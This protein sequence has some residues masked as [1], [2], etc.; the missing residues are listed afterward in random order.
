M[1]AR[2]KMVAYVGFALLFISTI[3]ILGFTLS[4]DGLRL[5]AGS[6]NLTPSLTHLFGTDWLGRDMFTRTIKGLRLSLTVGALTAV[7]SVVIATILGTA[8]ALFG[9][10]VD[11]LIS[12]LIDLFIGMP[13]LVFMILISFVVGGGMYGVI[14]G[15]ALTHWPSLARIVRAEVLQI[16]GAEYIRISASYGKSALFIAR[17]HILPAVFPQI[18]IGFLLMFPHVILHEAALTFLGF[19]LSPQTPAVGIILAEGMNHM[20]SGKWWL[21]VFP[22]IL[23]VCVVKMLDSIGERARILVNPNSSH[24]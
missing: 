4:G 18:M 17:K 6:K 12:W 11:A 16:K 1:N 2:K 20:S 3:I 22:G 14:L 24:D 21:V 15:V 23:L 8:A 5:N 7:I 13:H 10:K 9:K 19:G